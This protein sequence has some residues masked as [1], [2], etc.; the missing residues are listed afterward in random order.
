[1]IKF[2]LTTIIIINISFFSTL[3]S[4]IDELTKK[5]ESGDAE[6]QWLLGHEYIFMGDDSKALKWFKKSSEQGFALASLEVGLHYRFADPIDGT[7]QQY[8]KQAVKYFMKAGEEGNSEALKNLAEMYYYGEIGNSENY[9]EAIKWY[10]KAAEMGDIVAQFSLGE[11][12]YIGSVVKQ[13]FTEALKWFKKAAN[14]NDFYPNSS[15]SEAQKYIGF[16]YYYGQGVNKDYSKAFEWFSNAGKNGYGGYD[17]QLQ[18]GIMYAK[19]EGVK[20]DYYKAESIIGNLANK[21]IWEISENLKRDATEKYKELGLM[22]YKR[23]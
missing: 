9:T 6:A 20:Q 1:M 19:G 18:L 13:D 16:M 7:I 21:S 4:Q 10:K 3:F 8:S 2:Y 14:N 11:I 15:N 5:A 22:N 17:L 23:N 12:Y